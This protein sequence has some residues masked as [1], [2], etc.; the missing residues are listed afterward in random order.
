MSDLQPG[1]YDD[2]AGATGTYRWWDGEGWTRWLSRNRGAAA[3]AVEP[4]PAAGPAPGEPASV[5]T[6]EPAVEASGPAGPVLPPDPLVRLPLAVAVV[7]G[8]LLIGV[9]VV[10][11]VVSASAQ[12]LPSGPAVAPPAKSAARAVGYDTAT[13]AASVG[14][15]KVTLAG[16]PYVCDS[17]AQSVLPT[18]ETGLTCNAPVH[19]NYDGKR[20]TWSATT[21]VGVLPSALVQ[22]DN[23]EATARTVFTSARDQFFPREKTTVSG[24]VAQPTDVGPDVQAVVVAGEVHYRVPKVAS[25]YD[26]LLVVVVAL[27]DGTRAAV[28]SSRPNDSSAAVKTALQASLDSIAVR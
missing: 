15:L 1:W 22:G 18:L 23:L 19:A 11:V 26:R 2:P 24:L 21:A 17:S 27:P 28:I 3:P 6:A 7:V 14:K 13:R 16:A 20:N 5:A 9:V 25:R 12:G 8:V 4:A 10:G